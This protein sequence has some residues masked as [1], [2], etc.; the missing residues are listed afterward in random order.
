MSDGCVIMVY[1]HV[2]EARA[3]E[4]HGRMR[5]DDGLI[6]RLRLMGYDENGDLL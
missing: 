4:P 3:N 1:W 5:W 2:A 6:A